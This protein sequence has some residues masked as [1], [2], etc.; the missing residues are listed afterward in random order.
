MTEKQNKN[1]NQKKK[2]TIIITLCA[3]FLVLF[4]SSLAL[5]SSRD[6]SDFKAQAGSVVI[7]VNNLYLTNSTNI[8]PGDNDPDN[9]ENA[10]HGTP[11]TFS[12]TVSNTGN[13]SVRTRQ[14]ILLS[15]DKAGESTDAL[16]VSSLR[17]WIKDSIGKELCVDDFDLYPNTSKL[18]QAEYDRAVAAR[19]FVLSNGEEVATM[20]EVEEAKADDPTIIVAAVKYTFLG[21]VYEGVGVA[22]ETEDA[23]KLDVV[24]PRSVLVKAEN[25]EAKDNFT[26]EFAM[27]R[28]ATNKLQGADIYI[29]VV[30]EAMQYRNTTDEDWA[31]AT[32]ISRT[33]STS[34]I[35]GGY[36][37][38]TDE[39]KNGSKLSTSFT[40]EDKTQ[41]TEDP[42]SSTIDD[43]KEET[44]ESSVVV[45]STSTDSVTTENSSVVEKQDN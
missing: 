23:D 6:S 13:K 5:F 18:S 32:T 31:L 27:L 41:L 15:A 25:G 30:V 43:S 8:N 29:T 19:F 14:T 12:Y 1:A 42:N 7:N 28:N 44:D 10:T 45:D 20:K 34:G 24:S 26:F 39:N 37:P 38:D 33:F 40:R 21:N 17:L 4:A 22:A 9:P 3:V 36:V 2:I 16:D 11:H 35:E